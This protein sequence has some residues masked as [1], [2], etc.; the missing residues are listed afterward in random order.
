VS[1][2]NTLMVLKNIWWCIARCF[3]DRWASWLFD[4]SK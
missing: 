1:D 2:I 4:R 3:C